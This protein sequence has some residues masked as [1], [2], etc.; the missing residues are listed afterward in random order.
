MSDYDNTN[1]GS[2]FKN[3]KKE[4]EK[5]PDYT[6]KVNVGGEDFYLSAWIKE[7][8][9]GE[10]YMSLSVKAIEQ[11]GEPKKAK[12]VAELDGDVPF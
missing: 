1:R 9:S 2:L 4:S 8:K 11:K 10:K 7:S 3:G 5:H 12:P 6:G